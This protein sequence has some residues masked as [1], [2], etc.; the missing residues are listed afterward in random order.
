M[1]VVW[2]TPMGNR[3]AITAIFVLRTDCQWK[4]LPR[5]LGTA[6]AGPYRFRDGGRQGCPSGSGKL[7]GLDWEWQAIDSAKTGV[8]LNF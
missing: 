7:T 8:P 6:S 5:S 3:Q 2:H 4:A 1:A